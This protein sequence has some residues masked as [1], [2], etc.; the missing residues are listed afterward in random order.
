MKLRN[1]QLW[2]ALFSAVGVL[3]VAVVD[4]ERT[5][6]GKLAAVHEREPDLSDGSS[7]SACHGGW[8]STMTESCLDCHAE[9]ATHIEDG[10]GL[11]GHLDPERVSQC[12]MCH[13]EHHGTS[14]SIVNVQSFS[15]A[16]VQDVE[17]FDHQLI[18]YLMEGPHLELACV[19]CHTQADAAVLPT[20]ERR[21]MGLKQDCASCHEDPHQGRMAQACSDC[22]VQSSF[23][24][25]HSIG[26][27]TRLP[28][29][30]GHGALDCRECH[31]VEHSHSLEK[32]GRGRPKPQPRTCLECHASPHS[33][34][35]QS[36]V[37]RVLGELEESACV[38][39]HLHE[40]ESFRQDGLT[41]TDRQHAQSGFPLNRPHDGVTCQDCHSADLEEFVARYPGRDKDACHACHDDPH[42]GQFGGGAFGDAGCLACHDRH[43]F[44]PHTFDVAKHEQT[45]LVLT[46]SHLETACNDCHQVPDDSGVRRFAGTGSTCEECHR[47][48]HDGFF[49]YFTMG[50]I[51]TP[52]GECARCHTTGD[53]VERARDEFAH[54]RWTAFAIS[55]AH[56]QS[57]C[58]SCHPRS[59]K[60]DISGRSFGRV[61]EHFGVVE[62][63]QSCHSDPHRGRFDRTDALAEVDGRRGC[64][65]CHVDTSFR[66]FPH[67]FDHFSWTGFALR[68]AHERAD[69]S[70]CHAPLRADESG[71]TWAAAAGA[72]C[73]DCH[74]NPHAGQFRQA[75]GVTNCERCHRSAESFAELSF[76]H[77]RDSRFPLSEA[78]RALECSGCHQSWALEDG[79]QVM[80]YKPLGT[81]CVDCHG[82]H[83]EP[84]RRRRGRK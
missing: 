54:E 17:Q 57:D 78:H 60:P 47:D 25:L 84:L 31:A 32:L 42:D 83:N 12:A 16:G 64:V 53:F 1:P 8:T 70:S 29:I 80:R 38:A 9:V 44:E 7:C 40:H 68:G 76:N 37:A 51:G 75:D 46:G 59:H 43:Q 45:D 41:I 67:G 15:L 13:S 34:G 66:T 72:S 23:D 71:R 30:G 49:D 81:D 2:I 19:E 14:F 77:D 69:C 63:C 4:M 79:T 22:H 28:L 26:H 52:G 56:A 58:E 20:G 21:Y 35:F 5:S 55:G 18:G 24:E 27:D 82:V 61:R 10:D 6:P 73:S 3:L 36:G 65:R 50:L 74:S 48:A 39:C 11:H 62:G 33:R